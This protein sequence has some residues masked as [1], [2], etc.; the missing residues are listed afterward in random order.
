MDHLHHVQSQVNAWAQTVVCEVFKRRYAMHHILSMYCQFSW[1]KVH[2]RSDKLNF[3]KIYGTDK[4]PP[5]SCFIKE[6]ESSLFSLAKSMQSQCSF[7]NK[8]CTGTA[9]VLLI[10][11]AIREEK[12]LKIIPGINFLLGTKSRWEKVAFRIRY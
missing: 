8:D 4:N 10:K 5:F 7:E 3:L 11:N 1:L 12:K 9:Q 2:Q 6:F